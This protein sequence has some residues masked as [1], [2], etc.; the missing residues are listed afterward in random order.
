MRKRAWT[1]FLAT[2]LFAGPVSAEEVLKPRT[3]GNIT[4][5]SGGIGRDEREA[6]KKIEDD[7]NLRLLF[8][9]RDSRE[10]LA[11]IKVT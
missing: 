7:Y 8:A 5:V 3:Q 2:L 6:L 9:A 1:V 10:Y 4:F 11:D